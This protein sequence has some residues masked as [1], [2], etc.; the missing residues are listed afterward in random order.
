MAI[1]AIKAPIASDT[2]ILCEIIATP[3]RNTK[4]VTVNKSGMRRFKMM[5]KI[6]GNVILLIKKMTITPPNANRIF[7]ITFAGWASCSWLIKGSKIIAGII[8]A[9]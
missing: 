3:N 4:T 9:S 1:P 8:M 7:V 5:L 6:F 2:P